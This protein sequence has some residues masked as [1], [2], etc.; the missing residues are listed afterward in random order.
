MSLTNACRG[1][2]T[3]VYKGK[4]RHTKTIEKLAATSVTTDKEWDMGIDLGERI[5][6]DLGAVI[7]LSLAWDEIEIRLGLNCTKK[8]PRLRLSTRK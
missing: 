2:T 7:S 5:N 6:V 1:R 8:H 3:F 4:Q